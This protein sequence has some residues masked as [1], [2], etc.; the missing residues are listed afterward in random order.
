M[1]KFGPHSS[2][3]AR[4]A[5]HSSWANTPDRARRTLPARAAFLKRFED[6]VDPGGTLPPAERERRAES[7]RKAHFLALAAKSA[8]A[9][10]TKPG[11]PS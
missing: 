9:R 3:T 10:R 1:A 5:A 8:E 4:A 7:A 6:R 2:L 11:K